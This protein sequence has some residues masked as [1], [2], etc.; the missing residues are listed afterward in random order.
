[1]TRRSGYA[2]AN[3]PTAWRRVLSSVHRCG[4]DLRKPFG[5]ETEGDLRSAFRVRPIVIGLGARART[6]P[7]MT[8]IATQRAGADRGAPGV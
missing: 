2:S 6:W 7:T 3:S 8:I 5:S 4:Q 1:M